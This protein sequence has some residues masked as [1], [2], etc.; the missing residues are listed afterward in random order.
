MKTICHGTL[1][2]LAVVAIV[3]GVGSLAHGQTWG[4]PN[5]NQNWTSYQNGP[6][7]NYN[8]DDGWN[9]N[10]FQNGPFTS[11]QFQGPDGQHLNCNSFRNGPF[12]TTNCQ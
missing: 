12:V 3:L 7:T 10:S 11:S 6:F 1:F 8:S 9:G 2:A 4:V 5:S